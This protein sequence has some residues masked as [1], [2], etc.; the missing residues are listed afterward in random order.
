[1][2]SN[3]DFEPI[4]ITRTPLNY[5]ELWQE[6]SIEY[7]TILCEGKLNSSDRN[8]PSLRSEVKDSLDAGQRC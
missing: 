2:Y 7:E 6:D 4:P 5:L 8:F 3:M 1:M